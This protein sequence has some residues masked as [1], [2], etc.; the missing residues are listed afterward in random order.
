MEGNGESHKQDTGMVGTC[1]DDCDT[2]F[3]I[4]RLWSWTT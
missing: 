4:N 2:T 3:E 1:F